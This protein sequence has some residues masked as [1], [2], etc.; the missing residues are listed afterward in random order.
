MVPN[1]VMSIM[2]AADSKRASNLHVPV[3]SADPSQL[4]C[5]LLLIWIPKFYVGI[6]ENLSQ[7]KNPSLFVP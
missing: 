5:S 7:Y 2:F 6:L 4:L 3:F 1:T